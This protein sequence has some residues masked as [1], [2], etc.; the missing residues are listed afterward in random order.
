[1][2]AFRGRRGGSGAARTVALLSIA[3]VVAASIAACGGDTDD[4]KAGANAAATPPTAGASDP[5]TAQSPGT[6]ASAAKGQA[7]DTRTASE[8]YFQLPSGNLGCHMQHTEVRCE[9]RDQT[10]KLPAKPARCEGE[11]GK[12]LWFEK[13]KVASFICAG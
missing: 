6:T 13:G 10:Y 1:M 11:Y 2:T 5:A 4:K 7:S 3:L 8:A 12:S 9:I